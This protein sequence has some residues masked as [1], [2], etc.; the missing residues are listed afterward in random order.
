MVLTSDNFVYCIDYETQGY[1]SC[2]ESGCLDDNIC[3]CYKINSI[4][5]KKINIDQITQNLFD[6]F[7][8][9]SEL[10]KRDRKITSLVYDYDIELIDRYCIDRILTI[11]KV[12]KNNLWDFSTMFGYYGEEVQSI[13]LKKNLFNTIFTQ[14]EKCL[15]LHS[16]KE[17]IEYILELE[18]GSIL[19]RIKYKDY[20]IEFI[21]TSDLI[22]NQK[23]HKKKALQEE[24][25]D[26]E[27]KGICELVS[28]KYQVIDGY[29]R[30][31]KNQD[32]KVL[33]ISIL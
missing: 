9:D 23:E 26:T 31:S 29:H 16:L 20:K 2:E 25:H 22:F 13:Y 7:H 30:L 1:R 21:N 6:S 4:E 15:N 11:N 33:V 12:W 10:L 27:I 17:K 24:S 18:Y 3:R 19:D 5:I 14:I 32:E 28:G 8:S